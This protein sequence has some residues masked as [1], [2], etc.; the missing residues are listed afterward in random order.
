MKFLK[1]SVSNPNTNNPTGSSYNLICTISLNAALLT[2]PVATPSNNKCS[3]SFSTLDLNGAPSYDFKTFQFE[4]CAY[5]QFSVANEV[6][7]YNTQSNCLQR[8]VQLFDTENM[9]KA[10]IFLTPLESSLLITC[11]SSLTFSNWVYDPG[12]LLFIFLNDYKRKFDK[13][14]HFNSRNR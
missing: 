3:I 5:Y 7:T 1:Y 4:L 14:E 8:T 12:I 10:P 9:D 13:N 2:T 6:I 11:S